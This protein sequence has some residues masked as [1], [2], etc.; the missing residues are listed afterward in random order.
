MYNGPD[1][2]RVGGNEITYWSPVGKAVLFT[3]RHV[4]T[5]PYGEDMVAT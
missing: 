3:L 1:K 4:T 5:E 2:H